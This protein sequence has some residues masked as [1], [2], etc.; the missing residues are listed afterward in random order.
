MDG[1]RSREGTRIN[2]IRNPIKSRAVIMKSTRNNESKSIIR[3][4]MLLSLVIAVAEIPHPAQ[5]GWQYTEW[6]MTPEQVKSASNDVVLPPS[7]AFEEKNT[8]RGYFILVSRYK[9][10]KYHFN[11]IF[12]FGSESAMLERVNLQLTNLDSGI[13]LLSILWEY[14][15]IIPTYRP[16]ILNFTGGMTR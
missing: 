9:S 10:G 13:T 5:E 3:N 1:L 2:D 7:K 4:L 6:G 16:D 12:M 11:V 15:V 14:M 8:P